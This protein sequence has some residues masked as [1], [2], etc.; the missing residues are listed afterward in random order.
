ME[1]T[2]K[3]IAKNTIFL[4]FRMLCIMFVSLYTSRVVLNSLGVEDFG[5]Y[6]TVGGI[7]VMLSFLNSALSSGSSRFLTFELGKGVTEKLKQTFSTLLL[8]H[9]IIAF[10]LL[11]LGEPI[12]LWFL[13]NYVVIP[14]EKMS[15]AQVVFHLSIV[16]SILNITQV[17]YSSVIIAHE[18]LSVYAYVSIAEVLLKLCVAFAVCYATAYKIELYALLITVVQALNV[19]FYRIFCVRHYEESRFNRRM[20]KLSILKDV[21][22]FSGWSLFAAVSVPLTNQ[23]TLVLLNNYFS[24]AVVSARSVA[25]QVNNASNQFISNFRTASN[26]QIVKRYSTGD[27]ESSKSLLLKST[28]FSYYLMLFLALPIYLL[29]EPLLKVWLVEVPEYSAFFLR[30]SMIA[31]LFSV[32]DVSFYTALYA[33]GRL[34]ENALLSPLISAL[35][36][37][38]LYFTFKFCHSP[39]IVAYANTA[40]MAIIG[41]IVKPILICKIS[42]Y[43]I[44][45]V[46]YVL[47][48]SFLVTLL[49][50]P[51]PYITS[52]FINIFTFPGFILQG[53]ICVIFTIISVYFVGLTKDMREIMKGYVCKIFAIFFHKK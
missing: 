13:K 49:A 28:L 32:F 7:V 4:Y 18:K 3:T 43:T 14:D 16:T 51:I 6:Q 5:I 29:A 31:S 11:V 2:G 25:L 22:A 20:I 45:E 52:R 39:H 37:P 24:P 12:G 47:L 36:F 48:H 42:N 40:V 41:C 35:Q 46:L 21:G 38:I 9:I 34:K 50:V 17:P 10:L 30:W 33:K 23:G 44:K 8:A 26:P 53:F 27:L 19:F 1:S 15:A